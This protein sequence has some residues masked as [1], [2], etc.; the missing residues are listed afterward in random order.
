MP[1][2]DLNADLSERPWPDET[3]SVFCAG[4]PSRDLAWIPQ[5]A[6]Q[7]HRYADGYKEAAD[8]LY[9]S[10]CQ[11]SSDDLVFPLVFLYRQYIELRLKELLQS[12]ANLLDLPKNWE[13]SH[14]MEDLWR[15]L[16]SRLQSAS[17]EQP[18]R[19]FDNAE[20]LILELQARDPISMGFRYPEDKHG[21]RHLEDMQHLDVV[22]FFTAMQQLSAFLDGASMAISVWLD[23]K[24]NATR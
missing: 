9:Q 7:W 12:V 17:P 8:R 5:T 4:D 14:N 19:D 2:I 11:I 20:R 3:T 1:E 22:N 24:R 10:W 15:R 21:K 6:S 13:C 16:R 18:E 23:H